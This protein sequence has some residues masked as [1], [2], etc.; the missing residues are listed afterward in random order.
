MASGAAGSG[1]QPPRVVAGGG[2]PVDRNVTVYGV[3]RAAVGPGRPVPPV[4]VIHASA[5]APKFQETL[6]MAHPMLPR[7]KI[8]EFFM[9]AYS[10]MSETSVNGPFNR[11]EQRVNVNLRGDREVTTFFREIL[12]NLKP[13]PGEKDL[14]GLGFPEW[15]TDEERAK[16]WFAC[17][18]V[19]LALRENLFASGDFERACGLFPEGEE[20]VKPFQEAR[21]GID[22]NMQPGTWL[23]KV[24]RIA[25]G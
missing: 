22:W 6:D 23:E 10:R 4:G 25:R 3:A 11:L 7:A 5:I 9:I 15:F 2:G 12:G 18:L 14:T 13:E 17:G 19:H 16:S 21:E 8:Q 1:R 20:F 24:S